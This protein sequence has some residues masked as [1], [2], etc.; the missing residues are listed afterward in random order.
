MREGGGGRAE[1]GGLGGQGEDSG[2]RDSG[3]GD[4]SEVV[5]GHTGCL[6]RL[7]VSRSID[8]GSYTGSFRTLFSP[9][10]AKYST[11]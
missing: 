10:C 4:D 11:E 5:S 2:K 3:G 1:T 6:R 8:N 7:F 9:F